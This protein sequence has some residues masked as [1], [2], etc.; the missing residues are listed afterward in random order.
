MVPF[1]RQV[2][3]H[4]YSAGNIES[5]CFV[6][7]N[8]RSMAF[9]RKYLSEAVAEASASVRGNPATGA[10]GA[11]GCAP[12]P[13]VVPETYTINDFFS[14]LYGS[15]AADRTSLLLDLYDCYARLNPRAETL[16]E[17][18]YW[19]DVLLADFNDT[20][21]YL[22]D[23]SGLYTNISDFREIQDSYSYL[24]DTQREA[25][26]HFVGHFRDGNGAL[27]V[28]IG[29][30]SPNVKERFLHIW[31]ILFPL[32]TAFRER[33]SRQ[34]KAYE[35]MVYR[36]VAEM[37]GSG[38]AEAVLKG[39]FPYAEGFVF[40]G[41]NA[42][43]ECEK[44]VLG[45][46]RNA[47]LAEFC[48]DY[49][50]PLIRDRHNRSSFFMEENIRN[51]PQAFVPD[52]DGVGIPEISVISVPSA[53]GQVKQL[54]GIF[55]SIAEENCG[56]NLS[57]VG[58]LSED[59]CRAGAD[60][61]VVLPDENL[62][63]PVLNTVPPEIDDINVTMG[64]PMTSS[65]F[66][67]FMSLVCALQLNIRKKGDKCYFWHRQV[68][69]LLS[70][71]VFVRAAG[72][73]GIAA[74]AAVK[75]SAELYISV[76][77]LS[78][79]DYFSLVFRPVIRDRN[80]AD[81]RVIERFSF[82]LLEVIERTAM[83]MEGL[84]LEFAKGCHDC[85]TALRRVETDILPQTYIHLLQQLLSAVS[86]PFRG[87]PLK[88]L[89]IM[90]PLET[91]ALDFNNIVIM[92]ANEGVFPRR[93]VSSSFI[94]P[95]LRR[96][97]GLPTYEYQDAVWAYYFYRMI[98][99]ASR[100]WLLCDSR[101]EGI[102]SGEESRYIK[103][104]RYHFNLPLHSY[105]VAPALSCKSEDKEIP[106]TEEDVRAIRNMTFSATSLQTYLSCPVKFYYQYVRKLRTED[107][108]AENLDN[109][110]FGRVYHAVMQAL[111]LGD[112]AM[113]AGTDP[114]ARGRPEPVKNALQSV[115][116]DYLLRWMKNRKAIRDKVFSLMMKEIHV[117]EISGRNLVAGDVIVHYVVKTM[118]RDLGLMDRYGTD[119]FRI[120]G[121]E[122]YY[123][124]DFGGFR[125]GGYIDR[126][127]SFAP[128]EVRVVDYKTGKVSAT[129]ENITDE[130]AEE[131]ADA[132][133][134]ENNAARPKIALQLYVYDK[135][136]GSDGIAAGRRVVNC[137]YS[138]SRLFREEPENFAV[139][140]K[141]HSLVD[142]RLAKLFREM[143]DRSVPF[144]MAADGIPCAWCDFKM[145]CGR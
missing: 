93:N 102:R 67:V 48:W 125:L 37:F 91:R 94:P 66:Y 44:T 41:L 112:E 86:V 54:P 133:F 2:A 73:S 69:S 10:S 142:E 108:V 145:I 136:L 55:R 51:F 123:E 39:R 99:R 139:S 60:C 128:D 84:E 126:L 36:S 82:Y 119:S 46:M 50:G 107:E 19:G 49:S 106:R 95:E 141:F 47:G 135:F 76:E 58:R 21:K 103:Q 42:L 25:I 111:Y 81:R 96:G 15:P 121:L 100:V 78:S 143:T 23:A 71:P 16:D 14:K 118:E 65:D 64:Y 12:V 26:R 20:D 45:K 120:L 68:W 24:T 137:I 52:S 62:L 87:E 70:N 105:T 17:F 5:K 134:S 33:L 34:G 138:V 83:S 122:K 97:F 127:D 8:R 144:R 7:P 28:D 75:S 98:T 35:G 80:I 56:G 92:S 13:L 43:N 79:T 30:D 89:Q 4:Y 1:L 27:T 88:G 59:S 101:T 116:R 131:I 18:I 29:S 6:F 104:L 40:T 63:M 31:N 140:G 9:F 61:A 3:S 129:D 74:A 109:G 85:I 53:A 57:M 77:D 22:V 130:N 38:D 110:M 115:S 124:T 72:E 114:G 113:E 117:M 132:I 11:G 90:G 32:Y